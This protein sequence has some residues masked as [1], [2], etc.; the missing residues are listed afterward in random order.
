MFQEDEAKSDVGGRPSTHLTQGFGRDLRVLQRRTQDEDEVD[1]F[2]QEDV[3]DAVRREGDVERK[4]SCRGL[5]VGP[6]PDGLD[7]ES[8]E[9]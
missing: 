1:V 8:L 6:P 4:G 3:V 9:R 5:L 7:A 2:P